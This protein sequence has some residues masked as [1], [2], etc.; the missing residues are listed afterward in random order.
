MTQRF[1]LDENVV[2]LA[3]VGEDESGKRDA[4]CLLLVDQ[5]IVICHT[6]VVDPILWGKYY[7]QLSRP[8]HAH[9]QEGF[10]L[11]R[12]LRDAVQ[13][14][15]KVEIRKANAA[16]FPDEDS[17]PAGSQDDVEIVRLA[18]ETRAT[19]VTTDEA[20]RADLN[21]SGVANIHNLRLLSPREA[22]S[23]L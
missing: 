16:P 12:V 2:I 23:R 3:Q 4:T 10:R 8:G 13:R 22:L 6:W 5:I 7:R 21:S 18:V 20:L 9:P 17:I 19:L 14:V 11:I 15:G 1:I